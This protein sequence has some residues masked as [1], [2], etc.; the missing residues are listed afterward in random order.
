LAGASA[1]ATA[2]A[3]ANRLLEPMTNVS[4]VYLEFSR[5][6]PSLRRVRVRR[7]GPRAEVALGDLRVGQSLQPH[8]VQAHPLKAHFLEARRRWLRRSRAEILA[9]PGSGHRGL[10]RRVDGDGQL[11]VAA[12]LL[13]Q[14]LGDQRAQPGLQLF[15]D[16]LVRC[17]D[18]GG[19]LH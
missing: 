10:R 11:D 4:N 17:R 1:T 15:L 5:V 9:R 12:E 13:G 2:A 6:P 14:G 16:E 19:V 18:E 3:C 8:P 7:H